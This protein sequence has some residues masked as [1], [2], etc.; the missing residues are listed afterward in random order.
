MTDGEA[1]YTE[2]VVGSPITAAPN[3]AVMITDL[4]EGTQVRLRNG[5]IVEITANPRDGGWI[6]VKIVE[7]ANDPNT[8]GDEDMSF[9]VDVIDVVKR[10]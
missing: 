7:N 5:N 1:K 4:P 6:F 3:D 10:A 9:C 2:A 8:V